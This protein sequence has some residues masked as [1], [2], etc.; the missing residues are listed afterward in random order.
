MVSLLKILT[1]IYSL[2]VRLEIRALFSLGQFNLANMDITAQ[3]ILLISIVGVIIA[4]FLN[5]LV[6]NYFRLHNLTI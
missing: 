6:S 2:L 5:Q 1:V 4:V 3:K